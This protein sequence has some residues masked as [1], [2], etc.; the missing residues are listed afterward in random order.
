MYDC[1]TSALSVSKLHHVI[2]VSRR[3]QWTTFL[4]HLFI[5]DSLHHHG[6]SPSFILRLLFIPQSLLLEWTAWPWLLGVS[7]HRESC[8]R[9]SW[10]GSCMLPWVSLTQHPWEEC[11]TD[12]P[13]I[14]TL[15]TQISLSTFVSG[16][17]ILLL[18]WWPLLLLFI[19][20][21][22]S[23]QWSYLWE[24]SITGFRWI[25]ANVLLLHEG[26]AQSGMF[27]HLGTQ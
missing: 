4:L 2:S 5:S 25:S 13:R 16:S 3:I 14:W 19:Q 12:S 23:L 15:L 9:I 22:S 17:L 6:N 1:M 21:Q 26:T 20:H 11:W 7:K 24:S 27:L 8:T 18:F 10:H